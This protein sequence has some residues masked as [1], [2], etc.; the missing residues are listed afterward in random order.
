MNTSISPD[1]DLSYAAGRFII[2]FGGIEIL[3]HMFINELCD[4]P[5]LCDIASMEW[6]FEKRR[7]FCMSIIRKRVIDATVLEKWKALLNRAGALAERRNFVAH[8]CPTVIETGEAK[9]RGL[10]SWKTSLRNYYGKTDRDGVVSIQEIDGFTTE[11]RDVEAALTVLWV[12]EI[13][14]S[15]WRNRLVFTDSAAPFS[16]FEKP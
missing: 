12:K 3:T 8:A 16:I 9:E 6:E 11:V 4:E 13:R 15:A 2:A 7:S 5:S 10:H 1:S 14:D